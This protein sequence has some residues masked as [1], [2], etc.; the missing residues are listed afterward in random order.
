MQRAAWPF[1]SSGRQRLDEFLE[2]LQAQFGLF[3]DPVVALDLEEAGNLTHVCLLV[4]PAEQIVGAM[5]ALLD[6]AVF[7]GRFSGFD[8]V[9]SILV[10]R[11]SLFGLPRSE[12]AARATIMRKRGIGNEWVR[13][14]IMLPGQSQGCN[15]VFIPATLL[16]AS[17]P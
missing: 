7:E 17:H 14:S 12:G 1:S 6:G 13:T 5:A 3:I 10:I 8:T 2:V 11:A 9:A 15:R 4:A 16:F